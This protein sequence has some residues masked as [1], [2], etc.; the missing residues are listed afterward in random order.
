MLAALREALLEEWIF[1]FMHL[2]HFSGV[3]FTVSLSELLAHLEQ[4]SAPW[5][6]SLPGHLSFKT[7]NFRDL[8][9]WVHMLVSWGK[10]SPCRD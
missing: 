9:W 8:V 4:C 3:I 1:P 10:T 7:P 6:L 5:A 2:K